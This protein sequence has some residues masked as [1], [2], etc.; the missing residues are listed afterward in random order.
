MVYTG[1]LSG[2]K[3]T[4]TGR[5]AMETIWLRSISNNV[6]STSSLLIKLN[7]TFIL[8]KFTNAKSN[9]ELHFIANVF[10]KSSETPPPQ[11]ADQTLC[12]SFPTLFMNKSTKISEHH[13][14]LPSPEPEFE[15]FRVVLYL[16][17]NLFQNQKSGKSS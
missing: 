1:H 8:K 7:V 12:N 16:I 13:D 3:T 17:L 4:E 6:E 9:K 10:D 15:T 2:K 11:G 5:K 14:S